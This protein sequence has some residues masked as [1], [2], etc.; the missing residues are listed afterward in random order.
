MTRHSNA[1]ESSD[2][3]LDPNPIPNFGSALSGQLL[4]RP[5]GFSNKLELEAMIL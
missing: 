5:F 2:S 4:S 3:V 1:K